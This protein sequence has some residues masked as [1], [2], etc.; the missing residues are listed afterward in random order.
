MYDVYISPRFRGQ[1][2][3]YAFMSYVWE[4]N[5]AR[6][7]RTGFMRIRRGNIAAI[8]GT[9]FFGPN[10]RLELQSMRVLSLFRIYYARLA[11]GEGRTIELLTS[12][13]ARIGS[14]L[15]LWSAE[16]RLGY[17]VNWSVTRRRGA[18]AFNGSTI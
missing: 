9:R 2:L 1:R 15:L 11:G 18:R 17:R 12:A 7:V 14:G 6:G 5:R 3:F 16:G 4:Q 13:R 8:G 10:E